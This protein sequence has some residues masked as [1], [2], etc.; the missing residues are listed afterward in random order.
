M[1]MVVIV[2]IARRL[3]RRHGTRHRTGVR[4]GVLRYRVRTGQDPAAVLGTLRAA[5]V[6]TEPDLVDGESVM[7]ILLT[8][9]HTRDSVRDIIRRAPENMQGDRRTSRVVTFSDES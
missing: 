5:G 9:P 4:A 7:V 8:P 1:T 6:A 2:A 3:L